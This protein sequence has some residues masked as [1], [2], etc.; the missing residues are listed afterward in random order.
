[1]AFFSARLDT[2]FPVSA[3]ESNFDADW[4]CQRSVN[5]PGWLFVA[6]FSDWLLLFLNSSWT[7]LVLTSA[8]KSRGLSEEM[9]RSSD[10]E[11]ADL[12]RKHFL[13]SIS[14][15]ISIWKGP[16]CSAR[17]QGQIDLQMQ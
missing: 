10:K 5:I 4:C 13:S 8:L 9:S 14:Y 15:Q 17:K 3:T 11:M 1:M 16:M 7:L 12:T 6:R 2:D